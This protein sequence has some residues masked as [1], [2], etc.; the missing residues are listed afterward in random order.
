MPV[1]EFQKTSN[2]WV[3]NVKSIEKFKAHADKLN[4]TLS[5]GL[6]IIIFNKGAIKV[7]TQT[8]SY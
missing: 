5:L 8:L 2:A 4:C 7:P 6:Y 1:M 3:I